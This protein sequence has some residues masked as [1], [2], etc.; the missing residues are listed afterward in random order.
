MSGG[1]GTYPNYYACPYCGYTSAAGYPEIHSASCPL[2][3][4]R[5]ARASDTIDLTDVVNSLTGDGLLDGPCEPL[6]GRG[7]VEGAD[8]AAWLEESADA[9]ATRDIEQSELWEAL[10][11]FAAEH[12]SVAVSAAVAEVL[13]RRKEQEGRR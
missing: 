7:C 12:P 10:R 3:I 5:A 6:A 13:K 9:S 8:S 11:A 4:A 1:M 2:A